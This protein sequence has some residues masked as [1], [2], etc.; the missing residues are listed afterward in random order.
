MPECGL[1]LCLWL[2]FLVVT[3]VEITGHISMV[4]AITI[5]F[6]FNDVSSNRKLNGAGVTFFGISGLIFIKIQNTF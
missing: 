1:F 6:D 5:F 2:S 3:V 4:P